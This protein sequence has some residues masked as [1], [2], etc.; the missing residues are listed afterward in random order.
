MSAAD[1]KAP[2]NR[3]GKKKRVLGTNPMVKA[4]PQAV[5]V[6]IPPHKH[7]V[8]C[9]V[10]VPPGRETCSKECQE[11]WDKMIKRKKYWTYLPLIGIL[12]ILLFYILTN[13]G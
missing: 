10:S 9:G 12:L 5:L 7:C 8:N 1:K 2:K 6:N 3:S 4:E 11:N 13:L